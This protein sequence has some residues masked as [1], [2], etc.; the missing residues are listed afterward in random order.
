[1]NDLAGKCDSPENDLYELFLSVLENKEPLNWFQVF[2]NVSTWSS[3]NW[4]KND[5]KENLFSNFHM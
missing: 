5:W 3:P 1:M 2:L 4:L